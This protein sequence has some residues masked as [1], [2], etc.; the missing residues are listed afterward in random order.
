MTITEIPW[1]RLCLTHFALPDGHCQRQ[2]AQPAQWLSA[3]IVVLISGVAC[4]DKTDGL[5]DPERL[6]DI[7]IELPQRDWVE[8]CGQTRNLVESLVSPPVDSP[9]EYFKGCVTINGTRI[10][11]VAVRKKGFLGSLDTKRPSL[12]LNLDKYV[13]GV[14]YCDVDNLTL[15]NCKQDQALLSQWLTYRTYRRVGLPAPRLNLAKVTVNGKYLGIYAN[16]EPVKSA[17]LR[18]NFGDSD[19]TLYEGTLAD[20]TVGGISRFERKNSDDAPDDRVELRKTAEV[21]SAEPLDLHVLQQQIDLEEFMKFWAVES[22]VGFWDG[23]NNNQNNFFVYANPTDG[24]LHFIPWGADVSFSKGVL[25]FL[26]KR[27]ATQS[28]HARARLPHLL[29]KTAETRRQYFATLNQLLDT[30]WN[31]EELLAETDQ[32][33]KLVV[34]HL[35]ESQAD[36]FHDALKAVRRFIK[37]RRQEIANELSKGEP[38]APNAGIP[39]S[40]TVVGAVTA[41][42]D[43]QWSQQL[44]DD[45]IEVPI[46]SLTIQV[47]DAES[48][49]LDNLSL[50]IGQ[51]QQVSSPGIDPGSPRLLFKGQLTTDRTPVKLEL[52]VT[53]K[54][55]RTNNRFPVRIQ[56][57]LIEGREGFSLFNP[58]ISRA[59]CGTV[60][61]D[62]ASTVPGESVRGSLTLKLYDVSWGK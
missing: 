62:A 40:A 41:K 31:E 11:S 23:Y 60:E 49:Q 14:E 9:F 46:E 16:V 28:V 8:L 32:V 24:R 45:P 12:K 55:F 4:A 30:V 2:A 54:S 17:F 18:R 10:D 13:D 51:K 61:F 57:T 22:L 5:Y 43:G 7:R 21:L 52:T 36:S 26:F 37:T 19:G 34:D 27:G 58:P 56:G 29:Y 15:N 53:K 6:L 44:S 59:A 35:G 50:A 48:L 33:E 47:N 39:G 42:F 38:D 25:S 3:L 1:L 20:F